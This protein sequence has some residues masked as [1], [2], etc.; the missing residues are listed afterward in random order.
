M[1]SEVTTYQDRVAALLGDV[2]TTDRNPNEVKVEW[3][4]FSGYQRKLYSPRVDI[5]VGPF[6]VDGTNV[7]I[8]DRMVQGWSDTIGI[9]YTHFVNNWN[10]YYENNWEAI[11]YVIDVNRE[12]VTHSNRNARCFIAIE[13]ENQSSKKHLFE[14]DP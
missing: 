13:I 10:G 14:V 12:F 4:A 3:P 5:A 1:P 9:W 11:P 8:Y 7:A 2:N 6:S